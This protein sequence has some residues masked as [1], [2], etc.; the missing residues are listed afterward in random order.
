M[1]FVENSDGALSLRWILDNSVVLVF[2]VW[3]KLVDLKACSPTI[4][5]IS[6]GGS[7]QPGP[8]QAFT[9]PRQDVGNPAENGENFLKCDVTK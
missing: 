9:V 3:S 8:L 2:R 6:Q 1:S 5:P 7:S 4:M